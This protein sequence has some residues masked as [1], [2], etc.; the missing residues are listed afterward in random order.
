MGGLVEMRVLI[1]D[2]S[3]FIREYLRLVLEAM[4]VVCEEAVNGREALQVVRGEEVF[5]LMLLDL[6]MPVMNGL[7]CVKSLRD[8][9]LSPE[10][11]VMMITT[12]ADNSFIFRALEY[13]ADEFLMKPFT[14]ESLRE[15]MSM[16]GFALAA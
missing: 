10:T 4:G 8:T 5:D 9:N 16:M 15:K 12:E 14:A 13:G 7:E 3:R 2:D 1:V 6:N 11:K